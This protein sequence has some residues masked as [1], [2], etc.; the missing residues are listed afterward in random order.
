MNTTIRNDQDAQFFSSFPDRQAHIRKQTNLPHR[1]PKTH[2]VTYEY[3]CEQEFRSL[4]DHNVDRRRII[5]WRIPR[6]SPFFNSA[7]PQVMK[8]PFLLFADETIEDRDDI[9]LPLLHKIMVE[10]ARH[11]V[12]QEL[13]RGF[14]GL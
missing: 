6:D 14:T 1:D 3:E 7:N 11:Y 4:G 8:I 10:Q 5:L 9:L 13:H 12:Q 2:R